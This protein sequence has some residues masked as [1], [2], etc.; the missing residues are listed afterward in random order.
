MRGTHLEQ[1]MNTGIIN[2]WLT[3]RST[4]SV[5]RLISEHPQPLLRDP[6]VDIW[7]S[8]VIRR[9]KHVTVY[10]FATVLH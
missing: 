5:T 2:P 1:D 8:T 3:D 4:D 6:G 7:S 10:D 9:S